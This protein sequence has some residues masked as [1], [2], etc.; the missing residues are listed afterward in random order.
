MNTQSNTHHLNTQINTCVECDLTF[1]SLTGYRIHLSRIHNIKETLVYTCKI[2]NKDMIDKSNYNRHFKVCSE[3]LKKHN[4]FMSQNQEQK[5]E[6]QEIIQ[7]Q[8]C[9]ANIDALQKKYDFI[10]EQMK[11]EIIKLKT[12]I[13][14]QAL[15]IDAFVN[16]QSNV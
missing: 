4:E 7:H 11:A 6:L 1:K 13:D 10:L 16:D 15:I 3:K 9:I 8:N 14:T 2:C 12:K 5:Q